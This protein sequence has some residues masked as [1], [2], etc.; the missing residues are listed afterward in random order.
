MYEKL[1]NGHLYSDK[2]EN[3]EVFPIGGT[4]AGNNDIYA[5]VDYE[6]FSDLFDKIQ[7]NAERLEKTPDFRKWYSTLNIDFDFS[8]FCHMMSFNSVM[9][10]YYSDIIDNNGHKN[11]YRKEPKKLSE[12]VSQK[13]CACTEYA[14]LAQAYFQKQDIPT[15][16][17]G[18]ELVVGDDFDDFEPH[19]F[20]AFTNKG[21]T[22]I[23]DPVNPHK[24]ADGNVLPR[25]SECVGKESD[26]SMKTKSLFGQQKTWSY[27][28]G[29]HSDFLHDLPVKNSASTTISQEPFSLM[30]RLARHSVNNTSK[31]AGHTGENQGA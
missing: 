14:I 30:G 21:K 15:R 4:F 22:Y 27:A 5:T 1:A 11:F 26:Y 7:K 17:V 23:Y 24:Y 9:Q 31:I 28:G 13:K 19:S 16:Y 8:L 29:D 6:S 18:G 20:I 25:I 3:G 12:A 10:K 2:I